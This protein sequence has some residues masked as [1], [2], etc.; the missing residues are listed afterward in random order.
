MVARLTLAVLAQI[1]CT[2]IFLGTSGF[3]CK[4]ALI[5][6]SEGLNMHVHKAEKTT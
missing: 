4:N 6:F 1:S 2:A 5:V 3:G